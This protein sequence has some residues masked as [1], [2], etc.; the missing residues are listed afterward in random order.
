MK[1][2]VSSIPLDDDD[3]FD[4]KDDKIIVKSQK[5]IAVA[6]ARLSARVSYNEFSDQLLIE[7]LDDY[8]LLDDAAVLRLWF[9][10]AERFKFQ[11]PKDFFFDALAD[12]ARK[13]KFHPVRDYLNGLTW[14]GEKRIDKWLVTYAGAKDTEYVKAVGRL[15]LVAAVRRVRHPGCKFDEM[16]VLEGPQGN[17]KSELL[18]TIAV[19]EEWFLDSLPLGADDKKLIEQYRG[20]WICEAS[21]LRG[22]RKA[23]VDHMKSTLSR[24]HDRG[25]LSYD[26]MVTEKP[27][28]NII[29]GTTNDAQWLRDLTG[30]RRYWPVAVDNINIGS[31]RHDRDQLWA[32]AAAAEASGESIRLDKKLWAEAGQEQEARL[33]DE[34]WLEIL[35]EVLRDMDGKVLKSDVREIINRPSGQLTAIDTKRLNYAMRRLGWMDD[36]MLRFGSFPERCW[37]RG[38]PVAPKPILIKIE[39]RD[40]KR[41]AQAEYSQ[42][43][44][45]DEYNPRKEPDD[46]EPMSAEPRRP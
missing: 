30:N 14:D 43:K 22:M 32:E 35:Q 11:P 37:Y 5:N 46:A 33:E 39:F 31:L 34:P 2:N 44:P 15:V 10:V 20:K 4:R 17:L 42:A 21:E 13:N 29:V 26:R 24:T 16:L 25:R 6:L 28:H 3:D 36:K 40:G 1:D 7:G 8:K 41:I 18:R 19:R 45:K 27:R 38:D 23:E 9:L 12:L